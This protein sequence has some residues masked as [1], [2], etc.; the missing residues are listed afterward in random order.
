[1]IASLNSWLE[2]HG[3]SQIRAVEPISGG[4]INRCELLQL[5]QGG[6]LFLKH[7]PSSPRGIFA[8]EA[9]SLA[10]LRAPACLQIP[11]VIHCSEQF[12]LLEDL[13]RGTPQ[14]DYW[15]RLGRGLAK[16]HAPKQTSF[17]FAHD[18]YC[19]LTPQINQLS[20]DGYEFFANFRLRH[21][22]QKARERNLLGAAEVSAL[23][24]IAGKLH[25]WI[26]AATASL[27]HGDLWSGNIHCD[28]S[29]QAALVD[30]ACYWGW[31][32]ADLAMT[33]LFGGFDKRFYD[34]Y[35]EYAG[36]D[37]D[38]RERADLYNLYHLL[39]HLLLFGESYLQQLNAVARRYG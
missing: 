33:V 11:A 9:A 36:I 4:C 26:P 23:E 31:A 22:I 12:L 32:E 25:H 38:W 20:E 15:D 39:N 24:T 19:G 29:G 28:R 16:L 1:M 8:A 5:E 27:L 7:H 17:G 3:Y 21:L 13:G 18:N 2:D 34:A 35:A 30:P 37:T 6:T 10:A 14:A